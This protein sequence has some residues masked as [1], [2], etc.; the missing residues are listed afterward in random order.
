MFE[1]FFQWALRHG[2]RLLVAF[3]A[4]ILLVGVLQ[5]IDVVAPIGGRERSTTYVG[6]LMSG[7]AQS[8]SLILSNLF[9]GLE[10]AALP[11]FGAL[12]IHRLD[13]W[14]QMTTTAAAPLSV[15]PSWTMRNGSRLLLI[16]SLVYFLMAGL[17][18]FVWFN[19]IISAS[20]PAAV[21]QATWL[22]PLWSGSL[23]L[24]GALVLDRLDRRACG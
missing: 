10:G 3:A 13:L 7:M 6:Q 17:G 16:L 5:A 4:V 22:S 2:P 11:F 9:R 14:R 21:F 15:A 20:L 8:W 19:V 12:V 24:C 23:L 1:R 18:L